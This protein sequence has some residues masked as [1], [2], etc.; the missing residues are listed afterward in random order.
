MKFQ[1]DVKF[2]RK[3]H[4]EG[5]KKDS[6]EPYAFD[7]YFFLDNENR[8]MQLGTG[9]GDDNKALKEKLTTLQPLKE[10][11]ADIILENI[12]GFNR[13]TLVNLKAK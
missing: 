4:I 5:K 7:N 3:D 9:F 13:L 6:G 12:N 2:L 8:Q 1:T 10:Y 11:I